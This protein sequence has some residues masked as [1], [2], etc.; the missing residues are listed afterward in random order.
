MSEAETH[1]NTPGPDDAHG[2]G[3][4]HE[5][6]A[7]PLGAPDLRAWAFAIGGGA[8]GLLLVIAL[9]VAGQT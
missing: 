8:V 2:S 5:D 6:Q 9:F 1:P 4:G 3:H 7:E